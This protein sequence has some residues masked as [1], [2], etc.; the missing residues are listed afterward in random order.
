MDRLLGQYRITSSPHYRCLPMM[1]AEAR[2]VKG[3]V[4]CV[5]TIQRFSAHFVAMLCSKSRIL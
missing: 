1:Q 3:V 2:N 4:C 5:D